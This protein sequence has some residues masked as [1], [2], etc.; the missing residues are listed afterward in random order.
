MVREEVSSVKGRIRRIA[1]A[2]ATVVSLFM[3]AGGG[4][5]WK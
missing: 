3:A 5:N 1:Y 2:I 4:I